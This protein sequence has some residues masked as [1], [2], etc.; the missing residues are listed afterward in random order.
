MYTKEVCGEVYEFLSLL[1]SI[2]IN[3]IPKELTKLFKNNTD[4]N[5]KPHINPYTKIEEQSLNRDSLIIIA[6]LNLKYWCE[7]KNEIERLKK[8]YIKNEEIY[9]NK[10]KEQFNTNDIFKNKLKPYEQ[11]IKSEIVEYKNPMFLKKLINMIKKIF[12]K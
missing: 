12:K 6:T 3:K 2:Y 7:D 4:K 1:G 9:Q 11:S 5:Y 8:V 10:L